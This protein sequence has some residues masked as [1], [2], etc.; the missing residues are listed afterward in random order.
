MA[1]LRHRK[2]QAST[3]EAGCARD[4]YRADVTEGGAV[5]VLTDAARAA[6]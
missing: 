2:R 5:D 3:G 6:T 4:C 1:C